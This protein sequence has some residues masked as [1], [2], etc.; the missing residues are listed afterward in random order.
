[1]ALLKKIERLE[2]TRGSKKRLSCGVRLF[3]KFSYG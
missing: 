3:L 2:A 1:M